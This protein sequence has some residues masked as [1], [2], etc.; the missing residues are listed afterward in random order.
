MQNLVISECGGHFRNIN[1]DY[2]KGFECF[3]ENK[4]DKEINPK[5]F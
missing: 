1:R 4:G 5:S 3:T 2:E